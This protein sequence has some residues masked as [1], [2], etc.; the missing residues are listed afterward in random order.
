MKKISTFLLIGLISI[1]LFSCQDININISTP[2]EEITTITVAAPNSDA[3]TKVTF[4]DE[5]AIGMKLTWA[6]DDV[7]TIYSEDGNTRMGDF[8]CSAVDPITKSAQFTIEPGATALNQGAIYQAVYPQCSYSSLKSRNISELLLFQD[9]RE[10][11]LTHLNDELYMKDEAFQAGEENIDFSYEVAIYVLE[12]PWLEEVTPNWV[13]MIDGESTYNLRIYTTLPKSVDNKI[14][15]YY[16]IEPNELG[17]E[18]KISF[19]VANTMFGITEYFVANT[20]STVKFK[21]GHTYRGKINTWD[22]RKAE[23][24]DYYYSDSTYSNTLYV[25][26]TLIGIV[27]DVDETGYGGKVVSIEESADLAW[28][29]SSPLIAVS[30]SNTGN[31][32]DNMRNIFNTGEL[33][34]NFPAFEY[35]HNLNPSGTSSDS[36]TSTAEDLWYLPS[37]SELEGLLSEADKVNYAIDDTNNESNAKLKDGVLYWSSTQNPLQLSQAICIQYYQDSAQKKVRVEKFLS[38]K[39]R[40]ILAFSIRNY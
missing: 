17:Q 35:V 9:Q 40:A 36:Y 7:I 11:D 38:K 3:N 23:I 34:S 20:A 14:K 4:E 5:E 39:A 31:G 13:S 21:A 33:I 26:K 24:G 16:L 18:R 19:E 1:L 8:K 29:K 25:E 12:F 22:P 15:V 32:L 2:S 6:V 10:N 27:Y 37:E 30:E 28:N